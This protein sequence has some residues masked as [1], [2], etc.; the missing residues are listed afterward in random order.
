MDETLGQDPT[1]LAPPPTVG[2][3]VEDHGR[4]VTANPQ[5]AAWYRAAQRAV[6][7]RQAT[8]VLQLALLA[9]PGFGLA[10]ADLN[11]L[12]GQVLRGSFLH[13]MNWE[14]HHVQVVLAAYAGKARWAADLLQEHLANVG[15]DPL[16]SRIVATHQPSMWVV[17]ERIANC[18]PDPW[19]CSSCSQE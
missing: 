19:I 10:I 18:H 5:A 16:A 6:D 17:T 7:C 11:A 4:A 14:R 13:Q 15:C 1:P 9:D 3:A 12:T 8:V 2:F